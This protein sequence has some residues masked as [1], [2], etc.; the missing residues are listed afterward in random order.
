M[1]WRE[2]ELSLLHR[3]K[4]T[5]TKKKYAKPEPEKVRAFFHSQKVENMIG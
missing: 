4:T 2:R 3:E 5:K 1:K